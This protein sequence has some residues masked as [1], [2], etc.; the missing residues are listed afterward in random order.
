M[1]ANRKWIV[2]DSTTKQK[3]AGPF[4]GIEGEK[5]AN[6]YVAKLTESQHGNTT[7]LL[8]VRELL[9]S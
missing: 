9:L 7:T 3:V 1:N 5:D 6:M 2:I 4:E 8:E